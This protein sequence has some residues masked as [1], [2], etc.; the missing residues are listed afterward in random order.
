MCSE[1]IIEFVPKEDE[2]V[3]QLLKSREDIFEAYNQ[4][5]FE[6]AFSQQFSIQEKQEVPGS[7]RV[8]Y[9]MKLTG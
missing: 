5:A 4:Q 7:R 3:Q 1:L 9:K 6:T 2:K 8:I